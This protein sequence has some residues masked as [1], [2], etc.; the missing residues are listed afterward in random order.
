[1]QGKTGLIFKNNDLLSSQRP[2]FFLTCDEIFGHLR[3]GPA[4]TY[5]RLFSSGIPVDASMTEPDVPSGV[6]QIDFSGGPLRSGHPT[7][8]DSNQTPPATSLSVLPACGELA[9]STEPDVQVS[10]WASGI[11]DLVCIH[12]FKL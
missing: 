8:L 4:D 3:S 11:P 1:M 10:L 6:C 2:E 7:G 9:E 5:S 12:R